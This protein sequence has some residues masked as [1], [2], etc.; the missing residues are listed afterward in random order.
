MSAF[1]VTVR[2]PG[3]APLTY[4]A[5]APDSVALVMDAQDRFGPCGVSVK[6]A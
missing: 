2:Q 5:I 4:P 6:P 3:H 1:V